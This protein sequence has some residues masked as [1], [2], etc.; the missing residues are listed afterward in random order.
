MNCFIQYSVIIIII[1]FA[2]YIHRLDRHESCY[3]VNAI[4]IDNEKNA[5]HIYQ[6][7]CTSMERRV[8]SF[9]KKKIGH[10]KVSHDHEGEIQQ[11]KYLRPVS[12]SLLILAIVVVAF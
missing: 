9:M 8:P 6:P 5:R 4:C 10:T 11:E 12:L 3:E 1:V 7:F 2:I